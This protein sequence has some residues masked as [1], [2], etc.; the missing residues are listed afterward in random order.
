MQKSYI[1]HPTTPLLVNPV[2]PP[3]QICFLKVVL[4]WKTTT[5]IL[6]QARQ[7]GWNGRQVR[8]INVVAL[9][10]NNITAAANITNN[11]KHDRI[12]G[13]LS[14]LPKKVSMLSTNVFLLLPCS[15][16]DVDCWYGIPYAQPP[17]GNLRFR[18]PRCQDYK[19]FFFFITDNDAE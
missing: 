6:T 1:T 16:R 17:I 11:T 13:P 2:N 5:S 4:A 8:W 14:S 15:S 19:T 7:V 3:P 18:H 10:A 12:T 9:T